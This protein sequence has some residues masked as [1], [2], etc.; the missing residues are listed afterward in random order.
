MFQ[1]DTWGSDTLGLFT[2]FLCCDTPSPPV[3]YPHGCLSFSEQINRS[4]GLERDALSDSTDSNTA[5][6]F[7]GENSPGGNRYLG[8]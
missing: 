2:P 7:T 3:P 1:S 5:R 4:F 6:R 8:S